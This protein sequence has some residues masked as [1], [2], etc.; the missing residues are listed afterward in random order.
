M[1]SPSEGLALFV[2][3]M[4]ALYPP[5]TTG[6]TNFQNFVQEMKPTLTQIGQAFKIAQYLAE[7]KKIK[8]LTFNKIKSIDDF[9]DLV[10]E[11]ASLL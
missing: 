2:K 4:T 5:E 7:G 8:H 6:G 1:V 3:I 11:I 9:I 10:N